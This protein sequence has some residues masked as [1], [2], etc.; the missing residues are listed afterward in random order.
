MSHFRKMLFAA[1]AVVSFLGMG[2]SANAQTSNPFVCNTSFSPLV[3][4]VEGLREIVGDIV[5]TCT[6]GNSVGNPDN[7]ARTAGG[8]P[9]LA[10]GIPQAPGFA[11]GGTFVGLST[12]TVPAINISVTVPG[13]RITNRIFSGTNLTDALLFIDEPTNPSVNIANRANQNPCSSTTTTLGLAGVCTNLNYFFENGIATGAGYVVNPSTAPGVPV[14][15]PL[16]AGMTVAGVP[17]NVFQGQY[18]VGGGFAPNEQTVTFV[19][20]PVV[21][22]GVF[23]G[24]GSRIFRIKGIRVQVANQFQINGQIQAFISV[25]NPP[26]NLVLN[27]AQGVVGFVQRGLFFDTIAGGP[28]AQCLGFNVSSSGAFLANSTSTTLNNTG[29]LRFT[30]AYG[31]AFKRRGFGSP[32]DT[33][34]PIYNQFHLGA[35]FGQS[36][37]TV[38]YNNEST[39][40]NLAFPTSNGLNA[41]GIASNGTRLRA[42]F[43]GVPSAVR[44]YVS[45]QPV[46]GRIGTGGVLVGSGGTV[47]GQGADAPGSAYALAGTNANGEVEGFAPLG[48]NAFGGGLTVQGSTAPGWSALGF[49]YSGPGSMERGGSRLN[50]VTIAS[51]GTGTFV[52][53]V[54]RADDNVID[55][56]DFQVAIAFQPTTSIVT[57]SNTSVVANVSG[58]FAPIATTGGNGYPHVPS[59]VLSSPE[60]LRPIFT[61]TNCAT[62]LLYPFV[63]SQVGFNT[64]IAVSNTSKDPFGTINETGICRVFFYGTTAGGGVDP[65]PQNFTK[66]V[67]SGQSATFN[68]LFG[69]PEYGIQPV[70]GFVGYIIISCNFR[71]AHGFAFISDPSNLQTAHGYLALILDPKNSADIWRQRNTGVLAA[72][73]LDN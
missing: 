10:N 49:A 57:D 12:P 55:R 6:G 53:E 21:Q 35:A 28:Y 39:F 70:S 44:L 71:Y 58:N 66:A 11:V 37:P 46:T 41:A 13:T 60:D 36:N 2:N 24:A 29:A 27:N 50:L 20:V 45:V 23:P 62:N 33:P 8:P 3:V 4:R 34:D 15:A 18:G 65:T 52:W 26:A 30:E 51:D 14:V 31:V 43:V 5:I 47:I 42:R 54:L 73:A 72:E 68:L 7:T 38:N 22:P 25:Q 16:P 64:G 9:P 32:L 63:S 17:V 67:P 61:I 1:A 56:L 19:G 59:F 40:Y 69:G 48:G